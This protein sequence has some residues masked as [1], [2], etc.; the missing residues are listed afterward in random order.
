MSTQLSTLDEHEYCNPLRT[1]NPTYDLTTLTNLN[2][3]HYQP[4]P[5]EKRYQLHQ[6]TLDEVHNTPASSTAGSPIT[7]RNERLSTIQE[8]AEDDDLILG[9]YLTELYSEDL[10]EV[11]ETRVNIPTHPVATVPTNTVLFHKRHPANTRT[12]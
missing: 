5:H 8:E 12:N 7:D 11:D 1:T 2:Q 4:P 6:N 10:L 9:S 3:S